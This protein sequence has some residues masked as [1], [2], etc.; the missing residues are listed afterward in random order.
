MCLR[1]YKLNNKDWRTVE[2]RF[3]KKLSSWK[4][5]L[6]SYGERLVLINSVLSSLAMYM[7]S[8]FEIP[9]NTNQMG[10]SVSSKGLK[11]LRNPKF[12]STEH[13]FAYKRPVYGFFYFSSSQ[14]LTNKILGGQVYPSLFNIAR[15]KHSSVAHVLSTN[16]LN[17]SFR[18]VLVDNKLI[19]WNDLVARVAF[20][21]LDG[22]HDKAIWSL[23]KHGYFT[24]KS[25][26][27]FLAN[28]SVL[29]LN[30][31]LWKLK[32]PL[33]IKIFVWFLMKGV[34]L[35]K[36]NLKKRN[37]NGDDGC[38]FCNEK[39]TIQHLF[40][41]C[42]I[43]RFVWRIFQVAFGLKPPSNV[44]CL[45]GTWFEQVDPNMSPLVCVDAS[46]IVWS[47]W[48]CRNDC[49]FD[50]KRLNSY[51]QGYILDKVLES[52]SKGG[53]QKSFEVSMPLV[54]D[55]G[56]RGVRKEWWYDPERFAANLQVVVL[57]DL[58]NLLGLRADVEDAQI[59][60][61]LNQV[62]HEG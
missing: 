35:T 15:K 5:K 52:T 8:F 58:N 28:Q 7:M 2:E 9:K 13:M 3:Q 55:G 22:H 17:I 27:N 4:R 49:V 11:R 34:I 60:I 16:P 61:I 42:H 21:Q 39:E 51:L 40:F 14:W 54:R 18:R 10:S 30:K 26:Y 12:R 45:V 38:C 47:I 19:K 41:D 59:R 57:M 24:V 48:L 33:K 20:V 31:K 36:D 62:L 53:W 56:F 50:R 43:A 46:A 29:P 1:K 32:L 6:L 25:L 44:T 23:T 37:W